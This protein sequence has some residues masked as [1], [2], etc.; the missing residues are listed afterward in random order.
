MK[1]E[2]AR[3]NEFKKIM[4]IKLQKQLELLS[5]IEETEE[6]KETTAE[7]KFYANQY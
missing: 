4:R 6:K 3:T 7:K 2:F 5:K 1:E